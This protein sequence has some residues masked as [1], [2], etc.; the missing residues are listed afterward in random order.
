MDS[1]LL[2]PATFRCSPAELTLVGEGG[3]ELFVYGSGTASPPRGSFSRGD[4]AAHS[5]T[6]SV[7]NGTA[8]DD[9]GHS[10]IL[11]GGVALFDHRSG[12]VKHLK[13]QP[14]DDCPCPYCATLNPPAAAEC[15]AGRWNGCGAPLREQ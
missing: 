1:A 7:W 13:P 9:I 4:V 3:P 11:D 10:R 15:G 12:T 2:I 14:P 8:W 6:V 5:G